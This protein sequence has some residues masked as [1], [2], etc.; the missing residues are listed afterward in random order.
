MPLRQIQLRVPI[1]VLTSMAVLTP[2]SQ[3]WADNSNSE[4]V[5]ALSPVIVRGSKR[6]QRLE[7]I[8]GGASVADRTELEDAQVNSTLG[9]GRVFPELQMSYSGSVLFPS[10]TVR[11]VTSAQDFYNPALTVYVDGVPQLPVAAIQSLADVEQV[12]LLKGPQGTLYGKSAQG[13]VLNIVTHQPDDTVQGMLRAGLSGRGGNQLQANVSGPLVSGLLYG[14]VSVINDKVPGELDSPILGDRIGGLR[15]TAGHAKL[16]LAPEGSP[17]ELGLS[18]GRDCA[19]G[20][21]DVYV[22]YDD[23][24]QRTAYALD[25]LPDAYRNTHQRRCVNAFSANGKYNWQDW[26]LSAIVSSQ[27]LDIE[28]NYAFGSQ[29]SWQPETWKQNTQELRL[30]TQP[31]EEGSTRTWE[32]VFGLYRQQLKQRRHY[33]IDMVLPAHSPF[34]DSRSRNKSESISVYGDVTWY[35]TPKFD[36]STGVRL[37]RDKAQTRFVGNL[38]GTPV[39]ADRSTSENTWLG[40]IGAGYQFDPQWR[41][42]VNVVQGYKPVGYALAPTSE[43]DAE[44]FGRERSTSYEAGLRYAGED[45]RLSAAAYLVDTR[46]AQLYGDGNMGYQTLKNVG[47]I[48]SMGLELGMEWDVS[49]DWTLGAT[50]YISNAK[51]RRYIASTCA[52]CDSNKVPFVPEHGLTVSAQGRVRVGDTLL[53][54]RF[55]ARYVGAHYFDIANRLEQKGYTL[56]DASLAWSPRSDVEVSVYVNNLTNKAYRTYGFSYGPGADFAQRGTGR[57]VGATLSYV[58]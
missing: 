30:S 40:R 24:D 5:S 21:Q 9:L 8:N 17:W 33:I 1:A 20:T 28:R 55:A 16:R 49:K 6:D 35:M 45:L 11:G 7:S 42:Y 37:S 4:E 38:M 58:Y 27:D 26:Q 44:G 19:K 46:D 53:R 50:G 43:A 23:I 29:Y 34:L 48:R 18:A 36:V 22:L 39:A 15:S 32:G 31:R 14:S 41:G 54:P 10:I 25:G 2:T 57:V 51:F 3:V 47:D 12:E 13:G 52:D 56:L